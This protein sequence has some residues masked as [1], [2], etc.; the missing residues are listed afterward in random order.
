MLLVKDS[1]FSSFIYKMR[2]IIYNFRYKFNHFVAQINTMIK[3][4]LII[5]ILVESINAGCYMEHNSKNCRTKLRNLY[6]FGPAAGDKSLLKADDYFTLV[7]T[8]GIFKFYDRHYSA[9]FLSSNGVIELKSINDTFELHEKF[10]SDSVSFPVADHAIIAPFWS[11][12]APDSNGHV[13]YRVATDDNTLA[14]I[15]YDINLHKPLSFGMDFVPTWS[16]IITWFQLK[17]FNH[18]RFDYRNTFQLVLASNDETSYV[19]FNYGGLEWPNKDV[20]ASVSIGYNLGDKKFFFQ[21]EQ[22]K[23]CN[24]SEL[25]LKSNV[26]VRSRWIYRVDEFSPVEEKHLENK[27]V[28]KSAWVYFFLFIIAFFGI[29]S[30]FNTAM[31]VREIFKFNKNSSRFQMIYKK[32]LNDSKLVL[33]SDI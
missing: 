23:N 17:A 15:S 2:Q 25:Q 8:P 12:H 33:N 3:F 10:E 1:M 11:D 26:D 21:K 20:R 27:F 30:I 14:Q 13:F 22:P 16:C 19:M 24:I 7:Q 32:Q 4:L 31:W 9:F 5:Y 6:D 18:R 29:I 28:M